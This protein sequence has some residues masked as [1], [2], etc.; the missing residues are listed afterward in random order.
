MTDQLVSRLVLDAPHRTIVFEHFEIDFCCNGARSL[1]DA[2]RARGID[3]ARVV[4]AIAAADEAHADIDELPSWLGLRGSALADHI[5]RTHHAYLRAELPTMMELFEKVTVV[6]RLRHP[7]LVDALRVFQALINDLV[8][9]MESE[10]HVLFPMIRR[11]E[12]TGSKGAGAPRIQCA[13]LEHP[14]RSMEFEHDAVGGTLSELRELLER[15]E[16]PEDACP[17]YR[18]LLNGLIRLERDL[19]EHIHKENNL[20]FPQVRRLMGIPDPGGS[21]RSAGPMWI[22]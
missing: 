16:A 1:R 15:F 9:H 5:E 11:L 6:H 4:E 22:P 8:P 17:S 2:C 13:S 21:S 19:H 10:E 20:L 12:E 3:L 18:L 7:E 14:L